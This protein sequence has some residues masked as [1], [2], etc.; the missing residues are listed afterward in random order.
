MRCGSRLMGERRSQ[1]RP[2]NGMVSAGMVRQV[3]A[4]FLN[5]PE[6]VRWR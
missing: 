2:N 5:D 6:A 1:W 3:Q 4:H